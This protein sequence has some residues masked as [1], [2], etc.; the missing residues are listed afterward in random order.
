[1]QFVPS[2]DMLGRSANIATSFTMEVQM[3]VGLAVMGLT[4]LRVACLPY[5]AMA[6]C[7]MSCT[8]AKATTSTTCHSSGVLQTDS[9]E[10]CRVDDMLI[11]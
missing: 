1:M 8:L 9:T 6:A 11:P 10:A 5:D 7:I 3:Q 2:A 4:S